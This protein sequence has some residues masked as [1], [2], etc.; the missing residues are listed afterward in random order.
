MKTHARSLVGLLKNHFGILKPICGVE[1]GVW[2]GE[3]S[4]TLLVEIPRLTLHMVDPWETLDGVT[5]TMPKHLDEVIAAREEA[6][7]RTQ[8][9]KRIIHQMTSRQAASDMYLKRQV[10]FVFLD[11]C[12]TYESVCDDIA[13]WLPLVKPNGIICGHDYNGVGDR[14]CGWGVKRAVDEA[15]GDKVQVLPGNV[16]WVLN[17]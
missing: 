14:R 13:V 6:E 5:P 4:E 7:A 11:A 8:F 1:V 10:E 12:H 17:P 15:F 2:R 9:K 3:L 16:W